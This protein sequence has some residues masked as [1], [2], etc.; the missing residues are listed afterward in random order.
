MRQWD[1][2]SSGRSGRHGW[3][4]WE[5]RT[6]ERAA[7]QWANVAEIKVP[8]NNSSSGIRLQVRL[9]T[10]RRQNQP[11]L[12]EPRHRLVIFRG[13]FLQSGFLGEKE[14]GLIPFCVVYARNRE[15]TAN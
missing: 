6:N 7:I 12:F 8:V 11:A 10:I 3:T 2:S 13:S 1:E 5:L 14:K 9:D 15:R 4:V